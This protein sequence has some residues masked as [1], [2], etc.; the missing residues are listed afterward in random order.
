M[1]VTE[2]ESVPLSAARPVLR[3]LWWFEQDALQAHLLRLNAEDRSRRFGAHLSDAGICNR[4]RSMQGAHT[5]VLGAFIDGMLRGTAEV[6]LTA[7]G[8]T[9]PAEIALTVERGFR[10]L[11]LGR[12]LFESGRLMAANRGATA[13]TLTTQADNRAMQRIASASGMHLQR[14]G[15]ELTAVLALG[16][17]SLTS[18]LKEAVFHGGSL[19]PGQPANTALASLLNHGPPSRLLR[20]AEGIGRRRRMLS[21]IP[22]LRRRGSAVAVGEAAN[23]ARSEHSGL[24]SA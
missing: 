17:T 8:H 7:H 13:L 6:D 20:M 10:G 23:D 15:P 16:G 18:W 5:I 11:G 2:R 4:V 21:S 3:V 1:T 12:R 22:H 19:V 24:L 9:R 14:S